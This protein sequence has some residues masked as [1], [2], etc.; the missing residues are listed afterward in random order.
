[1]IFK[2]GNLS[3]KSYFCII[4]LKSITKNNMEAV[5][6]IN[7]P[8]SITEL[9]SLLRQQLSPNERTQ[10]A[11]LIQ[12]ETDDDGP[13]KAEILENLKADYIALKNGTL[14]T[15]PLKDLLNEI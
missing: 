11:R 4:I 1:M 3:F 8:L 2:L 13:S 12:A 9:S 14:K 5:L 15:R 10:L 6:N 7:I